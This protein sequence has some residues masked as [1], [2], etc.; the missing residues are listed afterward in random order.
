MSEQQHDPDERIEE[1]APPFIARCYVRDRDPRFSLSWFG[2]TEPGISEASWPL[3]QLDDLIGALT[4]LSNE[5][6]KRGLATRDERL[7]R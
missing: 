2:V 3:T 6:Q 7:R 5:C 4:R 1:L